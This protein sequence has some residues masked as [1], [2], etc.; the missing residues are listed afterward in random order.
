MAKAS[1]DMDPMKPNT[2]GTISEQFSCN[3]QKFENISRFVLYK[4]SF[5]LREK[6]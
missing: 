6:T 1:R 3:I 5:I 2:Q 4:Q